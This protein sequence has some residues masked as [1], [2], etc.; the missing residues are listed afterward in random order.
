M[1]SSK[2][3]ESIDNFCLEKLKKNAQK[4]GTGKEKE[5]SFNMPDSQKAAHSTFCTTAPPQRPIKANT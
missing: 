2:K 3:L 1:N 4:N 5:N